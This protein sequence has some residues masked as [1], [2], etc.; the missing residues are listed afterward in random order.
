MSFSHKFV[1][2]MCYSITQKR[3]LKTSERVFH[4]VEIMLLIPKPRNMLLS[5]SFPNL[6]L[7]LEIKI[8]GIMENKLQRKNGRNR[9]KQKQRRG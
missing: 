4:A 5:F 6:N 8:D 9:K 3:L 7:H 2:Q 1:F